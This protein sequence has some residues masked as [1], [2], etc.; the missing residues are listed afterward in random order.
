MCSFL[1]NNQLSGTVPASLG[2]NV[3]RDM[4]VISYSCHHVYPNGHTVLGRMNLNSRTL[5]THLMTGVHFIW[6]NILAIIC[7][8]GCSNLSDNMLTGTV[9]GHLGGV[10]TKLYVVWLVG[11]RGMC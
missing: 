5:S 8:R 9:P 2:F 4:Y 1:Q 7:M 10:L 11:C 6:R 3:L